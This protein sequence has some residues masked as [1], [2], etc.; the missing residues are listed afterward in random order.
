MNSTEKSNK[1]LKVPFGRKGDELFAPSAALPTG[2]DCQCIC[3]GCGAKLILKQGSRRRHFAHH[4]AP[5]S[6]QCVESAIHAAA[7]QVLIECGGLLVPEVSFYISAAAQDGQMLHEQEVLSTQRRIR[8]DHAAAEVTIGDI[9]PDVVG[10]RGE[11]QLLVEMFF[12]HR[13][14]EEKRDKLKRLG[15]PALEIDLSDLDPLEGFEAVKERVIESVHYKEWLVY[16]RSDE[17]LAYLKNKLQARV[18]SANEAHQAELERRK[19]ERAKL[20][21]LESARKVANVD[22]DTAFSNWT[23]DEQDAWLREQLGLTDAIPAFLS[24]GAYPQSVITVPAFIFQASIFERFIYRSKEGTKL[25]ADTIYPCL[26]RRFKL[27]PQDGMLQRLAINLYLRYLATARILYEERGK[28]FGPFYVEH[29]EVSLPLHTAFETQYDGEPLLS[30]Q[31]RGSGPRRRWNAGWPRW[32]AVLEE[33]QEVLAGSPHR[34]VLL[35]ALDN[36]SAMNSPA[37]PHHWA[38]PLVK[39]DVPLEACFDLLSRVGLLAR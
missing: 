2:L 27:P 14:D 37:S 25:T 6:D 24:R 3:P 15:F 30:D 28:R 22:V 39:R 10:Y 36:L 17:H 1:G 32:R 29:N 31:A 20:A 19:K 33:A 26:R 5:G 4:N 35:D 16:P 9:R 11:R 8:F 38:E 12:R 13:V 21:R 23:P 18:D 34:D 7:K